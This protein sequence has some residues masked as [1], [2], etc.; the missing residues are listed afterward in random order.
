MKILGLCIL[1]TLSL[2]ACTTGVNNSVV[3]NTPNKI[4]TYYPVE[5]AMLN[6]YTRAYSDQ[7]VDKSVGINYFTLEPLVFHSFTIDVGEYSIATQTYT[8]NSQHT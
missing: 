1:G 5:T 2:N 3:M 4:V 6:V 8:E 7:V